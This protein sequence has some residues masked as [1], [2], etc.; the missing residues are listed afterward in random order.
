[1]LSETLKTGRPGRFNSTFWGCGG[2][3]SSSTC[4]FDIDQSLC[5]PVIRLSSS[6]DGFLGAL[7]EIRHLAA[8]ICESWKASI[9][10]FLMS[11]ATAGWLCSTWVGLQG[12]FVVPR[13]FTLC[14][15]PRVC[16]ELQCGVEV[17]DSWYTGPRTCEKCCR[18]RTMW[19]K[20]GLSVFGSRC[21][22]YAVFELLFK[23]IKS[24][25]Y[26]EG[27]TDSILCLEIDF[28]WFSPGSARERLKSLTSFLDEDLW[29]LV[30][31]RAQQRSWPAPFLCGTWADVNGSSEEARAERFPRRLAL[32]KSPHASPWKM[33]PV[34]PFFCQRWDPT[35]SNPVSHVSHQRRSRSWPNTNKS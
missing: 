17:E 27:P 25:V 8:S 16:V 10:R 22:P 7:D 14:S 13:I 19:F 3:L 1:M 18:P 26:K 32:R 30:G 34:R 28:S 5:Y 29:A 20:I 23:W 21:T 9:W 6:E 31:T 35:W 4:K 12:I 11:F 15:C 2:L 24:F 33:M